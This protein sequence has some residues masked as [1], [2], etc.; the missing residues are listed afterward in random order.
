[1]KIAIDEIA[2]KVRLQEDVPAEAWNLDSEYVFFVG[3]IHIDSLCEKISE[4]FVVNAEISVSCKAICSR[5]LREVEQ[6]K[7]YDFR[8]NY[9]LAE[10][11]KEIDLDEDIREEILLNFPLKV[12]CSENCK[13]LC[14]DCGVNLNEEQCLCK[15]H[16]KR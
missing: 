15:K 8:R 5:C 2:D 9:N 7:H 6:K 14:K 1:M 4:N 10:L 13:G 11:G 12:L 16:N 3:N